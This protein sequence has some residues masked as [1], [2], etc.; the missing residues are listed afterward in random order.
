M[1]IA[2]VK[3]NIVPIPGMYNHDFSLN[4]ESYKKFI[5][6]KISDG[7]R[8]F[9]LAKSASEFKYMDSDER[10]EITKLIGK[11]TEISGV[12]VLSQPL[13]SGSIKSQIEEAKQM[14]DYGVSAIVVLPTEPVLSGKFISSHYAKSG[15]SGEKHGSYYVEYMEKFSKNLNV[16]LIFHDKP[17]SN[18]IGLPI[19]YLDLITQLDSVKGIKAHS[20]DP[21]SLRNL[22]KRYSSSHLCF[23]GFGKTVQFWS[24]EWGATA[25]HT[26]WS[27][28]DSKSDQEFYI[29]LTK[30][31]FKTALEIIEREWGLAKEIIK[32]GFAGYKELMR[33]NQ[34]IDNNLTRVPGL[35]VSKNESES[36]F[37]AFNDYKTNLKD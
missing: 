19:E 33:I 20:S 14:S 34:L 22:Y 4:L 8:I 29:S 32:T 37:N 23:D 21:Y 18:N 16:P 13:G 3:G 2:K 35:S 10:L 6:K 27:W 9:Y 12:V 17:L 1:N 15:F 31:D 28:F 25:R 36:L 24:S 11:Y 5:E 26:C 30:A 7:D